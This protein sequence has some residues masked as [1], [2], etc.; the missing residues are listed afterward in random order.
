MDT[1]QCIARHV[2]AVPPS[3]IRKFFDI[4]NTMEGV[5]SLGVGEPDYVTPWNVCDAAI[6]S[7][8]MGRTHYTSNHG[9]AELRQAIV[10]YLESRFGVRYPA[11]DTII[12]VGASEGLDLA[13][14]TIL[15][16]GDE[17]LVPAPSYVS[18]EPGV[19]FAAGVPVPV[20][21]FEKDNFILTPENVEKA[22]TPRTRAIVA[23]YPNNP[24]G[25]VMTREQIDAVMEIVRRH[26]LFVIADEIYAELTYGGRHASFA[27]GNEER[28]L[29][30]NGFSKAFA[31]TGWRLGY[32]CGPKPIVDTM[33]KIHQYS[34]LCAPIMS[35]VAG[36]EALEYEK[37]T[38]FKQVAD[39]MRGYNRR[40]T[41]IV[42]KFREMGLS[43][44]EPRGAFYAFPNITKTGLTSE[45]F[46]TQ[47]LQEEKVACVPGT[48]FGAG[49]EGFIR[50]SYAASMKNIMEACRRMANFVAR[51]SQA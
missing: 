29:L 44:F 23:P 43:C 21:T 39:M 8:E 4:A 13:F 1:N 27:A 41:F 51:H 10:E 28:T 16:P 42:E 45:E 30:I 14:R 46:C 37:R 12:T 36:I 11:A 38:D 24:T 19:R 25:A 5:I 17:V 47:L 48:A 32:A 7:I 6:H 20:E 33:V 50:C 9:M 2:A 18:Y 35:Q 15:N 40:R 22:I 31:M 3:G 49:G 26:D 34:I